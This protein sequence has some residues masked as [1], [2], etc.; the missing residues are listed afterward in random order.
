MRE[1]PISSTD[2]HDYVIKS[3]KLIGAFD[4]MYQHASDPWHQDEADRHWKAEEIALLLL[5][6]HRYSRALDV[7]CGKGRFTSRI[8][9]ATGARITGL[10]VSPTAVEIARARYSEIEFRSGLATPLPF[11]SEHFDL[12]V[13]AELLWYVLPDIQAFFAE[14]KRVLVPG[15]HYLIIQQFYQPGEQRFGN[16]VMETPQ[17]LVGCSHSRSW[18]ASR[19]TVSP[20]T[21]QSSTCESSGNGGSESRGKPAP[22]TEDWRR[23]VAPR[24]A[25]ALLWPVRAGRPSA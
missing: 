4:E 17:D 12:A 16:E 24:R 5:S 20:T 9:D 10:D 23:T 15:G 21:R 22:L 18:T 11:P 25:A 8:A 6:K 13:T 2:Y 19:S 7:G 1:E 3:G 14:V